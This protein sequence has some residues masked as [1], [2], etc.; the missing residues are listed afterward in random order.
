VVASLS[1]P[2]SRHA[3][4]QLSCAYSVCAGRKCFLGLLGSPPAPSFD[5]R[6]VAG[7]MSRRSGRSSTWRSVLMLTPRSPS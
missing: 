3:R 2:A 1:D 5:L 6:G 7:P 4:L